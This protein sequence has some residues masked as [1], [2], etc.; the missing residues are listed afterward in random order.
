MEG[1]SRLAGKQFYYSHLQ[2]SQDWKVCKFL[3]HKSKVNLVLY[4]QDVISKTIKI[5]VIVI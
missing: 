5:T 1:N 3:G 2:F 4:V